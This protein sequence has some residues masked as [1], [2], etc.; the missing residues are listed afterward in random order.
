[1]ANYENLKSAIQQV[2]K[3][4]GNNAITG[5][6][7]QQSLL[8]MINSLGAG[9]QFIGVATP[10]TNPGTPDKKVFYIANGKGTYTKFGGLEV[11]EDEVVA[12]T[13]DSSW[14][15]AQIGITISDLDTIRQGAE[16][17]STALQTESDPIYMADKPNLALKSELNGKVDKE[18]GKVLSSNDYTDAEKAKLA[19]LENYDD[20]QIKALIDGKQDTISDLNTIRSGAAKGATALQSETDPIYSADKPNIAPKTEIPDISG[21]ADK[22][23]TLAGYGIGDAYTKSEVDTAIAS[24]I[25]TTLNTEV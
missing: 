10:A 4:N 24:A 16:K 18:G 22:A 9:Y 2:V 7:L 21:K 23:T 8:A 13:W 15:K 11:T 6:L 25:T 1:M 20:T 3:T 5:E 17:G 12:L 14:R 19:G